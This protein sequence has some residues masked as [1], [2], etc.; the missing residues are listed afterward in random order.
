MKPTLAALCLVTL[1]AA[2]TDPQAKNPEEATNA[3]RTWG[4]KLAAANDAE[5]L[6]ERIEQGQL[7]C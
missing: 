6:D 5:T 1:L 7:A 2:C 3:I 4:Q